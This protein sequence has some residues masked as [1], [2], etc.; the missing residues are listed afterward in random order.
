MEAGCT[1]ASLV[2]CDPREVT[3]LLWA[4]VGCVTCQ[5]SLARGHLYRG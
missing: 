5:V 4:S 1:L 2:L 3:G